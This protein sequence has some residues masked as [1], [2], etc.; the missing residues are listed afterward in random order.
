MHPVTLPIVYS[1]STPLPM[2]RFDD[3]RKIEVKPRGSSSRPINLPPESAELP[4]IPETTEVLLH[5]SCPACLHM[6]SAL[7][8]RTAQ[9]IQ[10]PSCEGQVMP[11]QQIS[12]GIAGGS[13][14]NLPPPRKTGMLPHQG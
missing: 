14:T 4:A 8:T 5:F 7:R 13:K 1:T 2:S 9:P 3:A 12:M 10:C 11:P 6:L